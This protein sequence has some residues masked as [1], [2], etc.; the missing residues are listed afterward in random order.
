MG[1]GSDGSQIV[2]RSPT[3]DYTIYNLHKPA[4]GAAHVL[5]PQSGIVAYGLASN[6]QRALGGALHNACF[7][8]W[9]RS[10]AQ[11]LY[12][13]PSFVG[14]YWLLNW[15]IERNKYLNSKEGR[16]KEGGA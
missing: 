10:K 16:E 2:E 5:N 14:G 3:G 8:T 4:W 11:V 7:N 6:R 15:A 13:V 9:R 12:W 1:A